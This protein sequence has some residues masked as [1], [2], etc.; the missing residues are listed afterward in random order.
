MGGNTWSETMT[1]RIT[2]ILTASAFAF[3]LYIGAVATVLAGN[4]YFGWFA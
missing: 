3:G 4:S 2:T 1:R